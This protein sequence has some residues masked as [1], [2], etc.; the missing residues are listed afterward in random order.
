V[1]DCFVICAGPAEVSHP[2]RAARGSPPIGQSGSRAGN[3]PAGL[4]AAGSGDDG[5]DPV[6][7]CH[8]EGAARYVSS[9][10]AKPSLHPSKRSMQVATAATAVLTAVGVTSTSAAA[11]PPSPTNSADALQQLQDLSHQAEQLTETFKKA[12]DDHAARLADLDR[13]NA[14]AA[15]AGQLA[16]QAHNDELSHRDAVDRISHSS[17]EGATLSKLSMMLTS[18]SAKEFLDRSATL[19]TLAKDNNQA[20]QQFQAASQQAQTAEQQTADARTRAAAA[21]ADAARIQ[22]ELAG[23]KA[24]MEDQI[25]KTK[26]VYDSLSAQEKAQLAAPPPPTPPPPPPPSAPAPAPAPPSSA[27]SPATVAV[28]AALSKLGAPYVW[29]ATGP[30]S[31]DCSGLAQWAY[32]QAGISLPR[33]TYSQVTVGRAVSV[34]SMQPGDLVFFYSD[35]SHEGIY[36]GNG[37]VVHAPQTGETVKIT[38]YQYIGAVTAVR[39]VVG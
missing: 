4:T 20:I 28:N 6:G 39:R 9:H 5:T 14:D 35:F 7:G 34:S 17:Y 29:G 16:G 22:S 19:D 33:S 13:A 32:N 30:N 15:H 24:A 25:A 11:D 23:K 36:I 27:T 18:S 3:C 21:E 26:Q 1:R 10:R 38:P 12:E 8:P 37:N 2:N 31:F